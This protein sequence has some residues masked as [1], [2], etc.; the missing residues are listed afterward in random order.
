MGNM[1]NMYWEGGKKKLTVKTFLFISSVLSCILYV[2]E[3]ERLSI[4]R[5]G[6]G[7]G[8][9]EKIVVKK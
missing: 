8:K 5:G 6:G 3:R 4:C 7:G 9:K 2:E 1:I